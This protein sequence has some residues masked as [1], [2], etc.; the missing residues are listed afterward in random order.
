M[1][2]IYKHTNRINGKSYIGK[3]VNT[4]DRRWKQHIKE[5]KSPKT[6]FHRAIVKYGVECWD[7]E[8][9]ISNST[10][11]NQDEIEMIRV[12]RTLTTESGYNMTPGGDGG[13][14]YGEN[15]S[16]YGK[17]HSLETRLKISKAKRGVSVNSGSSNTSFTGYYVT[18]WGKFESSRKAAESAPV[19]MSVR[20]IYSLCKNN[21]RKINK[22]QVVKSAYLQSF[23]HKYATP[24]ELGFDF[25]PVD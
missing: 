4:M 9:L 3:T 1:G 10:N 19:K 21:T 22:V 16:F 20:S 7:S 14:G 18:P 23:D 24:R 5:S 15:N 17:T 25:I 11:I 13:S 6:A 2:T 8:I 12:H